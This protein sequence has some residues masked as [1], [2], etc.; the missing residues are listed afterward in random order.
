MYPSLGEQSWL[1]A[2]VVLLILVDSD[3]DLQVVSRFA[4]SS[5][6]GKRTHT[7]KYE[8]ACYPKF[9]M[10]KYTKFLVETEAF[11]SISLH[12]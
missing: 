6:S 5:I 3:V 1:V 12:P 2:S 11:Y 7:G 4:E 8:N 10:H 9:A